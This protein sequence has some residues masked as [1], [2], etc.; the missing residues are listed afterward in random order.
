MHDSRNVAQISIAAAR[1][2]KK[3]SEEATLRI[4]QGAIKLLEHSRDS[5]K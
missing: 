1:K 3:A 2:S 5:D 4:A